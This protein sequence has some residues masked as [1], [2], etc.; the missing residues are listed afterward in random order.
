MTDV[1]QTAMAQTPIAQTAIA[2]TPSPPY[3][4]VVFTSMATQDDHGYGA[5]A[6]AMDAAAQAQPGY[7]GHESARSAND[8]AS[9]FGITVSYW[10]DEAAAL[11]WK[12]VGAH[13]GAQ[14]LGRERWYADYRVRVA[15]VARE[16][17][18]SAT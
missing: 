18:P 17:G 15:H 1:A 4:A 13:L 16:Y 9:A 14:R 3:V 6:E 7:L 11:A 10:R 2:R 8:G 12:Q 5:M